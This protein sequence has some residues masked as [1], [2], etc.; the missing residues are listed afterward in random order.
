VFDRTTPVSPPPHSTFDF[1]VLDETDNWLAVNKPAPL[2]IHPSKPSDTGFTLWDGVRELLRYELANGGQASIVNRLDRET[3][4]VVLIA[5][6]A[7]SARLFGKAMMRRQMHKTYLAIVH[8]W[9]DW[10]NLRVDAPILR[11]GDVRES[12]IWVKQ[13]VH[14]NGAPCS[15]EF[16][17]LRRFTHGENGTRFALIEA[18]PR[19]GRMH[20]IRVHLSHLSFPIV[21]DKIYGADESC[22]LE[23]IRTGWTAELAARLLLPRQALHSAMLEVDTPEVKLRWEAPLT[24]DLQHFLEAMPARACDE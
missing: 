12:R 15:T 6:T 21:G 19:T 23:F 16:R 14:E 3:S 20:Q 2:Q 24:A 10:E 22:Y 4:G 17:V 9:P 11:Q 8:G 7:E 18:L 13:C 5:K 1:S